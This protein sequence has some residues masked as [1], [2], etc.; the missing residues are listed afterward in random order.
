MA[1]VVLHI[2]QRTGW[3]SGKLSLSAFGDVSTGLEVDGPA[4]SAIS[5]ADEKVAFCEREAQIMA[6]RDSLGRLIG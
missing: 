6:L 4:A 2:A 5:C 1:D 3:A